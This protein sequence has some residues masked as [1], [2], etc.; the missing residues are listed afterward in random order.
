MSVIKPQSDSES[1]TPRGVDAPST[2]DPVVRSLSFA[3]GGPLGR[4]ANDPPRRRFW[5]PTRV[6]LL[7]AIVMAALSWLQKYPCA[8]GG[9]ADFQQYTQ[10]CYSDIRA[11]WG[12][13]RLDQGA[14]PYLD[15]PVEYPVLT[16]YFMG[17]FG[18]FSYGVLGAAGGTVYYHLSA[19]VLLILG[20]VAVAGLLKLRPGRPWDAMML[21]AAPAVLFT[22]LVNWDWLPVALTMFFMVAF[23]RGRTVTAGILWGLA[24][25]A[26]FYPL[27]I[28]GPLL[29]LAWRYRRFRAALVTVGVAAA[30]WLVANLPAIIWAR[31][32]WYRFFELNSERGIDW[33]T[34]WYIV[35]HFTEP[36]DPLNE[37]LGT[38]PVLNWLYLVAFVVACVAIAWLTLFSPTPPRLAQVAFLVVAAFLLTGKVWS[39]QYVMWLIPLAVLARPQWRMFL[40]W[41][42]GELLYFFG[43]YSELLTVSSSNDNPA[44]VWGLVIPEWVFIAAS[45][46]RLVTLTMLVVAVV[47]DVRDPSRDV[48]RSFYGTDPDA[49]LLLPASG[50]ETVRAGKPLPDRSP[51]R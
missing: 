35:R 10:Y 23:A 19:I 7:S 33:G 43:F 9:W 5:A 15:H 11:L 46:A 22:A 2:S 4:H 34:S 39:Q 14:I 6:V 21:V 20:V 38:I 25:A 50:P 40:V 13:E 29:L 16:G 28:A 27:L 31:E 12:A 32:G 37:L 44:P 45:L 30:T 41:Q 48:I 42:V 49:G 8:D 24:V 17:I 1:R 47:R 26:K 51:R 18:L 3:I 36:G